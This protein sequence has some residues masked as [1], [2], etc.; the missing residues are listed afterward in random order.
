MA[1]G[2]GVGV[3]VST[4][5]LVPHTPTTQTHALQSLLWVLC[6][7]GQGGQGGACLGYCPLAPPQQHLQI[8][9]GVRTQ[10]ARVGMAWLLPLLLLPLLL[11]QQ[12]IS[13]QPHSDQAPLLHLWRAE[14]L[15]PS[16]QQG[17]KGQGAERVLC[18]GRRLLLQ[19]YHLLEHHLL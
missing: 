9:E 18:Y 8:G 7:G 16:Q 2:L 1:W 13:V 6:M 3:W 12:L 11:P 4:Q 5:G 15:P 10:R 14:L 19:V 17:M